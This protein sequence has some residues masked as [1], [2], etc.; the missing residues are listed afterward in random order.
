MN[1]STPMFNHFSLDKSS[2]SI[3]ND[4]VGWLFSQPNEPLERISVMNC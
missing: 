1:P 4:I 2:E 3:I